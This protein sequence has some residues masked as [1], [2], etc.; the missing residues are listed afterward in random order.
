M[1][2]NE[3]TSHVEF[4]MLGEEGCQHIMD[5]VFQVLENTGCLVKHEGARQLLAN[6]GCEVDGELVKIPRKVLQDGIATAPKASDV[7]L[8][9]HEGQKAIGFEPGEVHFGPSITTVFF[10]D[11]K[12]GEKRRGTR[13]DAVNT[14][15]LIDGLDNIDWASTVA[16]IND[17]DPSITDLYEVQALLE[18][19]H[20]PIMYWAAKPE[21]LAAIHEMF[22]IVAGSEDAFI[23][24]PFAVCLA[25]PMDPLVQSEEGCEQLIDLAKRKSPVVYIAGAGMGM[26]SPITVAGSLVTGLAD[27]LAGLLI[28]Q[29]ANPGAPFIASKFSDITNMKTISSYHSG[30]EFITANMATAEVF[31]YLGIPYCNNFGDSDSGVFDQVAAFD[32]ALQD[33]AAFISGSAMN[34]AAGALENGNLTD[35]AVLVYNNETVGF[36]RKLYEPFAYDEDALQVES[37]NEVGPGGNFLTEDATLELYVD[38]WESDCLTPQTYDA[39]VADPTIDSAQA[40]RDKALKIIAEGT[41]HKLDSAKSEQIDGIVARYENK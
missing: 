18:N 4:Q 28:S 11:P 40:L 22:A 31:R 37:I 21:H 12:T 16:S 26:T 19:T 36:L 3:L 10:V 6:V 39:H 5:G 9:T 8:Y 2:N 33:Q 25:C 38:N 32:I 20:K 17:G 15:I 29:L 35:Y 41:K 30:P 1:L 7:A 27:T 14:S 13:A 23:E 24:K 34:F